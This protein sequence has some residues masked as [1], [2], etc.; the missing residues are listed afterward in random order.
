MIRWRM[1]LFGCAVALVAPLAA[2]ASVLSDAAA[3]LQPGRFT[4]INT[5]LTPNDFHPNSPGGSINDWADSGIWDP[6]QRKF[7]YIGKQAGCSNNYRNIVY[8]EASNSWS[9]GS[10]PLSSGCGHGYDQNTGDPVT[11]THYFRPYAGQIYRA[12]GSGWSTLPAL[13]TPNTI[14]GGLAKS[15]TGVLYSDMIWDVYYDDATGTKVQVDA[16]NGY[17][18]W[19]LIGDYHNIAEYDPVHDVFLIAGGNNSR[20]MY[21]VSIVAGSPVR[22]RLNDSPISIGVGE[23]AQHTNIQCDPV[24]G[25]FVI[26]KKESGTF[27]GYNIM[28]DTWRTLG[29]AGNGNFPPLPTGTGTSAVAAAINTHGVIMYVAH[30]SSTAAVYLYK[31]A[32]GG[33]AD[34]VP[35]NRPAQLIAR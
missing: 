35:P 34:T 12:N 22:A 4:S 17:P 30:T 2:G 15:R 33:P 19:P 31:H 13:P 14:V 1:T 6:V 28:T 23:Y 7:A 20:A 26:Y 18:G 9:Y 16:R 25:E 11:G 3:A 8:D 5:G 10:V 27:Y 24:T 32:A 29:T 21:R